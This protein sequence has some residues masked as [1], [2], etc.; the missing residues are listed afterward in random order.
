MTSWVFSVFLYLGTIVAGLYIDNRKSSNNE[1]IKKLYVLW[2]YIFLCFGYMVGSDWRSYESVYKTGVGIE[3]Y[4]SEPA[5]YL[6]FSFMPIVLPDYWLFVGI[7]KCLY[8]Y[9]VKHLVSHITTQWISV[10][11]ILIPTQ[12]G[13]MLIQNPFRYMLAIIFINIALYYLYLYLTNDHYKNRKTILVIFLL[14]LLAVLFHNAS[15]VYLLIIPF[16]FLSKIISKINSLIIFILYMFVTVVTSNMELIQNAKM[17]F[18]LIM[19][20]YVEISDYADYNIEEEE[21]LL[22][23]A[24]I[25][26]ILF[27]I[28]ILLSKKTIVNKYNN[29]RVVFGLTVIFFFVSRV[30]FLI[31]TGFRLALPLVVF[32]VIIY[33]YML[34]TK[35]LFAYIIISYTLL[36]FV[37]RL[38]TMYDF[39]P[40][41][42][43]IPYF[44]IGHK[45][46]KERFNYN[47]LE[48]KKRTGETYYI[49][50]DFAL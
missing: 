3:R 15:G 50:K 2:L 43:S 24:N 20:Q 49:D 26:R 1:K 39:I 33:I 6:L 11:A 17:A 4:S 5:S 44:V 28:L 25:T 16:L 14:A 35:R 36:S 13:L 27:F 22:S 48:Y 21:S 38:W 37:N 42:N 12:L 9:S 23:L 30:F 41:T 10:L 45:N 19:Q 31:P 7:A 40:Y 34:N 8:L 46:Y 29:G 18:F 47:L 32:S